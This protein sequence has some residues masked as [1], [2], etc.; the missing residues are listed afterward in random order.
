MRK[1]LKPEQDL[2]AVQTDL[3]EMVCYNYKNGVSVR[4]LATNLES[5][6]LRISE[7]RISNLRISCLTL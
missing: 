6:N 3:I 2:E 7:S 1:R 5:P 4:A